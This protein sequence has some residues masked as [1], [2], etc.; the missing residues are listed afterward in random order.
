MG[1]LGKG[2]PVSMLGKAFYNSS[3]GTLFQRHSCFSVLKETKTLD[4]GPIFKDMPR[5]KYCRVC[6]PEGDSP[7]STWYI[8][9]SRGCGT[10]KDG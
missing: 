3:W 2:K 10:V 5:Y 9:V 6:S 4:L 1:G 7:V 8:Y